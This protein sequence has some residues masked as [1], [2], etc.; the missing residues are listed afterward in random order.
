MKTE[1]ENFRSIEFNINGN[2]IHVAGMAHPGY[3]GT[4]SDIIE[5]LHNHRYK[6]LISTEVRQTSTIRHACAIRTTPSHITL[7]V[8]DFTAPS[9]QQLDFFIQ[10]LNQLE[11]RE[12]IAI[13]CM[14]GNGRTG[15]FMAATALFEL[16]FN[17]P[18]LFES[19]TKKEYIVDTYGKKTLTSLPVKHAIE[20]VRSI[21]NGERSVECPVQVEALYELQ[22]RIPRIMI[23]LSAS[24]KEKI[25]ED[26][27]K[28]KPE[29]SILTRIFRR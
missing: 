15:T 21:E 28:T 1:P 14:G 22:K 2:N 3:S 29:P 23:E 17:E 13:H 20:K 24:S 12:K 26:E 18:V 7:E 5:Y 27:K 25:E 6:Y 4:T 8:D 16:Y 9:P 19:A 10:L 11:D